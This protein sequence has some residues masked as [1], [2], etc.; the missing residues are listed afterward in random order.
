MSRR[1]GFAA[2]VVVLGMCDIAS[3]QGVGII[4]DGVGLD[5][6]PAVS[7]DRRYVRIG[8]NAGFNSLTGLQTFPV[9]A[10]V[11]G[12]GGVGFGAGGGFLPSAGLFGPGAVASNGGPVDYSAGA[13]SFG[14]SF[15]A[16]M[17]TGSESP[18]AAVKR[19][20]AKAKSVTK[21][22]TRSTTKPKPSR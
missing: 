9:P 5:A 14:Q 6:T 15:A 22:A 3:A 21:P 12:G 17:Q 11:S 16:Y 4:P 20:K 10:A 18:P 13:S 2:A 19:T 1:F 7:A 8:V